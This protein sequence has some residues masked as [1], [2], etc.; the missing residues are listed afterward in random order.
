MSFSDG[1]TRNTQNS[2][3]KSLLARRKSLGRKEP[4]R[5]GRTECDRLLQDTLEENSCLQLPFLM[6]D[7]FKALGLHLWLHQFV[8]VEPQRA[9][10]H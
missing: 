8:H 2:K 4:L 7:F 6:L 5:R 1:D 10:R 9:P 3:P